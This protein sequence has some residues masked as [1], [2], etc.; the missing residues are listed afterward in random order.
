[1]SGSVAR[2]REAAG[3]RSPTRVGIAFAFATATISGFATFVNSFGVQAW[4]NAGLY[5]TAKNLVAAVLLL[6]LLAGTAARRSVG[7]V[8]RPGTAAQWLGVAAIA[9]V[10]GSVPF[11]LFFEGLARASWVQAAFIHKTL[12]V[13][14]A[15]LAL[16]VL[17][18]RFHPAHLGAIGLLVWGQATLSGDLGA[19][20]LGAGEVMVLG[21]TLLWSVE[22][23]LAKRL[24]RGLS[25]L[26]LAVARMG[27]GLAILV[28]YVVVTGAIGDLAGIGVTGWGWALLTGA[29]LAGYVGTWYSALAR[30]PALD[31]T[32]VLV[33]GGVVAVVFDAALRGIPL[34]A[35]EG[36]G[37]AMV[38][39]GVVA[40]AALSIL[41]RP[42]TEVVAA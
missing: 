2:I 10:G 41:R 8:S 4:G 26:T 37:L 28:G 16:F 29:I 15:L 5:T 27:G 9:V 32:A 19:V 20:R 13:W 42:R 21:A 17:R 7:G 6:A 23:I 30:A 31:V 12:I 22:V 3:R 24:L 11:L 39:A 1:M 35:P 25:P 34:G 38:T 36:A 40:V 33:F 18:E 14:V